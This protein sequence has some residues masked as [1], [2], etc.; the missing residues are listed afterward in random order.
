MQDSPQSMAEELESL[1]APREEAGR[2]EKPTEETPRRLVDLLAEYVKNGTTKGVFDLKVRVVRTVDDLIQVSDDDEFYFESENIMSKLETYY[3]TFSLTGHIINLQNAAFVGI[4]DLTKPIDLIFESLIIEETEAG[5]PMRPFSNILG[6]PKVRSAFDY[7]YKTHDSMEFPLN[8]TGSESHKTS[9]LPNESQD[10]STD[11]KVLEDSWLL[12]KRS[13]LPL[14]AKPLENLSPVIPSFQV[15]QDELSNRSLYSREKLSD[16]KDSQSSKKTLFKHSISPFEQTK[17]EVMQKINNSSSKSLNLEEKLG[18]FQK[19]VTNVNFVS[20]HITSSKLF[21]QESPC[22]VNCLSEGKDSPLSPVVPQLLQINITTIETSPVDLITFPKIDQSVL[23]L[24]IA[25]S[26]ETLEPYQ[27]YSRLEELKLA[28]SQRKSKTPTSDEND[29]SQLPDQAIKSLRPLSQLANCQFDTENIMLPPFFD[30]SNSNTVTV[31]IP[32]CPVHSMASHSNH[33][34]FSTNKSETDHQIKA[35]H[36]LEKSKEIIQ[37]EDHSNEILKNLQLVSD[38]VVDSQNCN[39]PVKE[40]SKRKPANPQSLQNQVEIALRIEEEQVR[41]F[42]SAEKQI[43]ELINHKTH[44]KEQNEEKDHELSE[45]QDQKQIPEVEDSKLKCT[46]KSVFLATSRVLNTLSSDSMQLRIEME[47]RSKNYKSLDEMDFSQTILPEETEAKQNKEKIVI[48]L[49]DQ[50]RSQ[51]NCFIETEVMEDEEEAK[52]KIAR[53]VSGKIKKVKQMIAKSI[54]LRSNLIMPDIG[55]TILKLKSPKTISKIKEIEKTGKA[56][57]LKGKDSDTPN[58]IEPEIINAQANDFNMI[59]QTT[60]N[61][62]SIPAGWKRNNTINNDTILTIYDE[63]IN[64]DQLPINQDVELLN[65]PSSSTKGLHVV[66]SAKKHISFPIQRFE[67]TPKKFNLERNSDKKG[68]SFIELDDGIEIT[69]QRNTRSKEKKNFTSFEREGK[70]D[71][72]IAQIIDNIGPALNSNFHIS[73][74]PSPLKEAEFDAGSQFMKLRSNPQSVASPTRKQSN[75]TNSQQN[76]LNKSLPKSILQENM[77]LAKKPYPEC[78]PCSGEIQFQSSS[79]RHSSQK[80][81]VVEEPLGDQCPNLLEMSLTQTLCI[82][83]TP[84]SKDIC[85][86]GTQTSPQKVIVPENLPSV[87]K[88]NKEYL[89]NIEEDSN[90]APEKPNYLLLS[91]ANLPRQDLPVKVDKCLDTTPDLL[92]GHINDLLLK[93]ILNNPVEGS[94]SKSAFILNTE[95]SDTLLNMLNKK[96]VNNRGKFKNRIK[97]LSKKSKGRLILFLNALETADK[98]EEDIFDKEEDEMHQTEHSVPLSPDSDFDES[99]SRPSQIQNDQPE[100]LIEE[101][102]DH[103]IKEPSLMPDQGN[104]SQVPHSLNEKKHDPSQEDHEELKIDQKSKLS[105]T[106]RKSANFGDKAMKDMFRSVLTES[107]D[108]EDMKWTK[109]INKTLLEK[110]AGEAEETSGG[111]AHYE[112]LVNELKNLS[113]S[114]R[115]SKDKFSTTAEATLNLD[116]TPEKNP[117]IVLNE[118]FTFSKVL[119]AHI[120]TLEML[121]ILRFNVNHSMLGREMKSNRIMTRSRKL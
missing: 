27:P 6:H 61:K 36:V 17:F 45:K 12:G 59:G 94:S 72:K 33:S 98:E 106:A 69:Q 40:S 81:K 87:S 39:H 73:K 50:S 8:E 20:A 55:E 14:E 58:R 24:R 29:S 63:K 100:K 13:P 75:P 43:S 19:E 121:P 114:N 1:P 116:L 15:L 62:E 109:H 5:L 95:E 23:E 70:S 99:S 30:F 34:I 113:I 11:F 28:K 89:I 37:P 111:H 117:G 90:S 31:A 56:H 7:F 83:G 41:Q 118:T 71:S 22:K 104:N 32:A 16:L 108:E 64:Y 38:H 115:A 44:R 4:E 66:S 76:S 80:G 79:A 21:P 54:S 60:V 82:K 78:L 65:N 9:V 103:Q 35:T 2:E 93:T 120:R 85:N 102:I 88:K 42:K 25:E 3:H 47:E 91:E 84:V 46:Q 101:E 18:R 48:E 53:L 112:K 107:S 105:K 77:S 110:N 49:L 86:F 96:Q 92:T 26:G 74:S 52:Q 97:K 10:V 68:S 67:H 119:L 57:H 51:S